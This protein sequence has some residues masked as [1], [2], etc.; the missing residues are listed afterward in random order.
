MVVGV[1]GVAVVSGVVT[2]VFT[3]VVL[4]VLLSSPDERALSIARVFGPYVPAPSSVFSLTIPFAF[5]K[6]KIA[7]VRASLYVPLMIHM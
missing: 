5:W 7:S 6:R 4:V 2:V 3:T 1:V